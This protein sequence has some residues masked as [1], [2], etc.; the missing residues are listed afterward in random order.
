MAFTKTFIISDESVNTQ[1][2]WVRTSGIR[3]DAASKNLP[4][5]YDHKT[6]E[7]PLGHWVNLRKEGGNL[8]GDLVIKGETEREKLYISKIQAGDIKGAT[9][10]ADPITW[11]PD[12]TKLKQGQ[13]KPTLDE[14][15]LFEVSITPLPSNKNA[16]ALRHKGSM[17]YLN[18]DAPNVIPE[19]Q[20]TD[21]NEPVDTLDATD[22]QLTNNNMKSIALKLGLNE[23]ATE[24]EILAAIS[25]VQLSRQRAE[26]FVQETLKEAGKDL[27]AEQKDIFDSLST[28]D[29]AKALKYV[30]LSRVQA[31][32]VGN[33]PP[34]TKGETISELVNKHKNDNAADK[35]DGKDCYDYLQRYDIVELRRIHHE[36]PKRYEQLARDY[37]KGVR[38]K[39]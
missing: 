12:P 30:Q 17:I 28:T 39:K 25:A 1:G 22:V 3:L 2:F 24:N 7:L 16:L 32:P 26:T 23:T 29:P 19:L 37:E 15:D 6:W 13:T 10:G 5:F 38:Y 35:A 33:T 21:N 8:M 36:E 9:I 20:K 14:C 31:V 34:K 11:N 4:A 27:T 18:A